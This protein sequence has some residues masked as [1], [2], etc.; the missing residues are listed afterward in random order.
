MGKISVRV[1]YSSNDEKV[2]EPV[3]VQGKRPVLF[4]RDWLKQNK[5]RLGE[6]FQSDRTCREQ[7][8]CSQL[9]SEIFPLELNTLLEK[10]KDL[11]NNLGSG[12]KGFTG[13]LTL[14][15]VGAKIF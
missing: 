2:L 11:F 13:T 15:D 4:G 9:G 5:A 3:V 12:I 10:N 6:Y 1:K 8:F 14:K 7:A